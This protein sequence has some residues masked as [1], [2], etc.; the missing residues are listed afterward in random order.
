VGYEI[1]ERRYVLDEKIKQPFQKDMLVCLRFGLEGLTTSS[2]VLNLPALLGTKVQI[3]TQKSTHNRTLR[4]RKKK[5][6][7]DEKGKKYALLVGDTFIV[8]EAGAVCITDGIRML[9][10]ADVC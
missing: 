5:I 10:Y 1:R 2:K 9:T 7:K 8:T 3:L 4:R 6:K